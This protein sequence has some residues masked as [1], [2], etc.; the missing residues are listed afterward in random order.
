MTGST[1]EQLRGLR[2]A[3]EYAKDTDRTPTLK[4]LF[5]AA[6]EALPDDDNGLNHVIE[7]KGA[8]YGITEYMRKDIFENGLEDRSFFISLNNELLKEVRR[9]IPEMTVGEL[10]SQSNKSADNATNLAQIF[11]VLDPINAWYN[12]NSGAVN[13]SLTRA[14]RHRGLYVHPWTVNGQGEFER[15][16][17]GYHG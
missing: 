2:F 3:P 5:D 13:D 16:F 6:I 1:F 11:S 8:S 7:I 17:E 10:T 14:A 4:E 12:P 15:I 9:N